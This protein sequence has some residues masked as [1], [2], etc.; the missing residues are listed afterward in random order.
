MNQIDKYEQIEKE[1]QQ[2]IVNGVNVSKLFGTVEAIKG[3]PEIA[4]F[5]FRAK[6]KWI[7]GGHNRTTVNEFYGACQNFQRQNPFVFEKDEP[8]VLL[9]EDHGANPV[10]YVLAALDGCLTTS[11]IYHAAVQGI[12]IDEVETSY[13]GDLNLHG[14][15][16][17][18]ENIRNGYEKIKV[19]FKIKADASKEKLQEL[20]QLAQKRS[21][22]FDIVSNPTSVD[23][24]LKE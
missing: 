10:E 9:G 8:P 18:N 17:L 4:K 12:K 1:Q 23:V 24:S 5:N 2:Q 20:V 7:N 13:L 6:G 14:F 21:P 16:G 15:L 19:E 3:N 11:L 22:V